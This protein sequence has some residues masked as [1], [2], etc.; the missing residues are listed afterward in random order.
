MYFEAFK[1]IFIKIML[2]INTYIEKMVLV[3]C[4]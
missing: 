4:I 2:R 3:L 1:Y